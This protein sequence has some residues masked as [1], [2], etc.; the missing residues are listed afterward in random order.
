MLTVIVGVLVI[1]WLLGMIGHIA[2]GF[3]HLLL[4]IALTVFI[5][6]MLT[7]RKSA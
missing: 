6:N 7:G 4:A 2:G 5:Y 1:L 3:I